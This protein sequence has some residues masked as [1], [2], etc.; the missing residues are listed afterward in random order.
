[1]QYRNDDTGVAVGPTTHTDTEYAAIEFENQIRRVKVD[2]IV[3]QQEAARLVR[4]HNDLQKKS[5]YALMSML[6]QYHIDTYIRE[7]RIYLGRP[8]QDTALGLDS[9][10]PKVMPPPKV[11]LPT[12]P[13]IDYRFTGRT[14]KSLRPWLSEKER[15]L[16]IVGTSAF[17]SL[18]GVLGVI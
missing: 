13:D 14:K 3:T 9:L 1:M 11:T 12:E 2:G 10:R 18:L 16:L 5:R 7:G 15:W 17:F 4:A 8:E 6:N